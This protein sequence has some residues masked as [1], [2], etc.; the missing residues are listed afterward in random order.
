MTA[1]SPAPFRVQSI[2]FAFPGNPGAIPLRDLTTLTF[3]GD[4]PEWTALGRRVPA[5]FAGGSR[6]GIRVVFASLGAAPAEPAKVWRIVAR[7]KLG[8]GVAEQEVSLLFDQTGQTAPVEFQLDAALP[9]E[10]GQL[11]LEWSWEAS[12][13]STSCQLGVTS[14]E[15][16]ISWKPALAP[17]AW[18]TSN[19]PGDGPAGQPDAVWTYTQIMQWSCSFA[20][21]RHGEEAICD[22]L[23]SGLPDTGLQYAISAWNVHDM[24]QQ[25][26]GYCGGWFRMFQAMA[27][28]QGVAI[29]RRFIAVDWRQE[30]ADEARWCALVV[31][32]PGLNREKPAENPS[33]FH[34]VDRHPVRTSSVER[35]RQ[36]RYRFWGV[37][38]KVFDGHCVN[39][40]QAAGRWILYDASFQIRAELENFSLPPSDPRHSLPVDG[41]GS[42][43]EAYLDVAVN[44]MLG[45][46]EHAGKLF[47]TLHPDPQSP[48]FRAGTTRNGLTMDTA[49]LPKRGAQL[50]FYWL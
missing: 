40:L 41:L 18:L 33:T 25:G 16:L 3:L 28:S 42:F 12:D 29:E 34:D 8:P 10:I 30:S 48:A 7:S 39:F 35:H 11:A 15:L 45:T 17:S 13:G 2:A 37:P 9:E 20:A 46:L 38:G 26:G 1:F 23:L 50:T 22:A 21:G 47:R 19:E 43:K 44:F 5:A 27:G 24:L 6:P 49:L 36:R 32:A 14:Q 4:Q 31:E